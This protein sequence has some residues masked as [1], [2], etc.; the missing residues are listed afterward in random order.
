[1]PW[2]NGAPLGFEA[3]GPQ[4]ERAGVPDDK[5]EAVRELAL[6]GPFS[7]DEAQVLALTDAMTRDVRVP[8]VLMQQLQRQY[9]AQTLVELV[10]TVAAYNMVSRFLVALNVEH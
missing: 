2:L 1:M 4:A 6:P 7:P 8:D 10:A 3:H 9:D 5:I